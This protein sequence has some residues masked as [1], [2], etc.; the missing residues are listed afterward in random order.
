[1]GDVGLADCACF[2][3]D[4]KL[5]GMTGLDVV[6]ALRRQNVAAPVILITSHPTIV[7]KERAAKA[8]IPIVEKPLL[9]NALLERVR[10]ATGLSSR[11]Y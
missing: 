9:G 1:M 7:V 5:P 8:G 10:H 3:I 6:A 2:I 4:E 11:A